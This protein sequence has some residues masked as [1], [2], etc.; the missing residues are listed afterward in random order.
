[1]PVQDDDEYI[2]SRVING[3]E[4]GEYVVSILKYKKDYDSYR[5][6]DSDRVD[7]TAGNSLLV[8]YYSG[9]TIEQIAA[10][11][12]TTSDDITQ[13]GGSGNTQNST[14][15][16]STDNTQNGG[17]STSTGNSQSS[18][19]NTQNSSSGSSSATTASPKTGDSFNLELYV[20]I[21]MASGSLA[22]ALCYRRKVNK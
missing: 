10:S 16:T 17:S 19:S 4:A 12:V 8:T 5:L 13:N 2:F 3:L 7:V 18:G 22:A 14:G 9:L 6:V 11:D 15:D 21:L 20:L 1:M